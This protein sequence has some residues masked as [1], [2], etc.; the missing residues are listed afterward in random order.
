MAGKA[1]LVASARC[2][3]H[4]RSSADPADGGAVAQGAV[5]SS[6]VVVPEPRRERLSPL[7]ARPAGDGI[8]P[9]ALQRLDEPLRLPFV[10]GR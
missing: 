6:T 1:P 7:P 10:R 2:S 5:W 9:L 3:S 8:G 4:G